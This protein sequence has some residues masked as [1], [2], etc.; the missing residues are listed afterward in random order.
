MSDFK[1]NFKNSLKIKTN[2][3]KETKSTKFNN[4]VESLSVEFENELEN[5]S[6]LKI[7]TNLRQSLNKIKVNT[8]HSELPLDFYN[9]IEEDIKKESDVVIEEPTE[10]DSI[11]KI[12]SSLNE[13]LKKIKSKVEFDSSIFDSIKIEKQEII[14]VVEELIISEEPKIEVSKLDLIQAASNSI[15]K[16]ESVKSDA[17]PEN[18]VNFFKE[19]NAPK[20]DPNIKAI[21]NRVKFLEDWL[22]KVSMA[23]PGSGEVNFKYL[24]DVDTSA[25]SNTTFLT[26]NP[27]T[28]KYVFEP[29]VTGEIQ[30]KT[31][32]ITTNTYTI[33][34][35]DYYVGVDVPSPTTITLPNALKN[36]RIVIIK[37]ESGHCSQNPISVSG[38]ID[39]D[40]GGFILK[41]DNGG[42]QMIYNNGWR[43]I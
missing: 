14:P 31:I 15:T 36:G 16:E 35:D 23:G 11:L 2:T 9:T 29:V 1:E 40:S 6:L 28:K 19:P 38:T 20:V 13:S 7:K 33:L 32:T 34:L 5:N 4:L 8:E 25:Q 26:Y 10:E 41:V 42:V 3:V 27:D 24:D 37:D 21:Q 43:I 18:Y 30:N 39:N 17:I 12:K 22:T